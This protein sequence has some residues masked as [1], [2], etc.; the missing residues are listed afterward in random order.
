MCIPPKKAPAL[1][2]TPVETQ[3]SNTE[4]TGKIREE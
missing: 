3:K 4:G 2:R 1:R